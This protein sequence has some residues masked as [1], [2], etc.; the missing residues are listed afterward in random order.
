M[1]VLVLG[2]GG[3]LGA[4]LVPSL[5][6]HGVQ[7]MAHSRNGVGDYTAD[8]ADAQQT[9]ALVEQSN[10]D[11][12]IHLAG[13]TDV[14]R[15]EQYPQEAWLANVKTVENTAAACRAIG[16]HLLH[17][18]TD[19]VYDRD[20]PS[21]E[22]QAKPGNYY[23]LTKYAGELAA[24]NVGATVLRTNFF[25]ASRHLKRR[26]LTDW[27][28]SALTSQQDIQVFDDVH[29]SPLSMYTLCEVIYSLA[30]QR[31]TGVFNVG[32]RQGLSK[33]EFA[34][35][36]ARTLELPQQHMTRASVLKRSLKAWRPSDMRMDTAKIEQALGFAMPILL[37]EIQLAAKDYRAQT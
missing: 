15:C 16:A 11:V 14:D 37:E 26:S 1:K 20:P 27:L 17:I 2:A 22:D 7:A 31:P 34:F 3:M 30:L 18:S 29:F 12:V 9:G 8:L 13:L 5:T 10:A 25:G 6:A 19:Q 21:T 32:S 36:F 4:S 28:F 33:A 35:S 23:A 24:L